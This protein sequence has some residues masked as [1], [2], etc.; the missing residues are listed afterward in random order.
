MPWELRAPLTAAD[1]AWR[2]SPSV[3]ISEL[4]Q[5]DPS[6][7]SRSHSRG[8]TRT[9]SE[10]DRCLREPKFDSSAQ[11]LLRLIY[12]RQNSDPY[13]TLRCPADATPA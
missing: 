3:A 9:R 12:F 4:E 10:C 2:C 7:A 5:I 1:R 13:M 6:V 11:D 8:R